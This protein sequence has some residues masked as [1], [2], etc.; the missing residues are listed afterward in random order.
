MMQALRFSDICTFTDKQWEATRIADSCRYT[1]FGGSR[2]PGKSHWLRWYGIYRLLR[3]AQRGLRGVHIGMFCEDYPSLKDRQIS[4]LAQFPHWLGTLKSTKDAGLGFHLHANFGGGVILLRNLD[5]PT[6]Y[7]SVEF[8]GILVDE[9]TK[10]PPNVFD[11]LRGSLRWPGI[12]DTFFAAAT[13]PNGRYFRWVRDYWVEGTLPDNLHPLKSQFKF[14]QALPSSNPYL[15]ESYWLELNTLPQALREAWRDGNWY[16]QVEGLVFDEFSAE[17][18][19][20]LA[21]DPEQP[22]ELAIDDGY[23]D[24]RATLFIQRLVDGRVLVFDELYQVRKLEEETIRDILLTAYRWS[25]TFREDLEELPDEADAWDNAQLGLWLRAHGVKLPEV[26][27]VSHEATALRRRLREA[28][29]PARNWLAVKAG[30]KTTSTRGEAV[31]LTRGLIRDGQGYRGL[32]VNRT[33]RHLIEELTT[34]Y[35]NKEN[36][37]GGFLDEPEDGNDHACDALTSWVWMRNRR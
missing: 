13:N 22:F 37:A 26:A 4:K 15:D 11:V 1:L 27:A 32:L 6:K 25:K 30:G 34:G 10:N 7:Q 17:N 24:P 5:D 31:K 36:P 8:A 16:V 19:T 9:L 35:R 20:E 21:P 29:I 3:W 2:G 28:D 33:C 23:I 18:I 12:D 14:I